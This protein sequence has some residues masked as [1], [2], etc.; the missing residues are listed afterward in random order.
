MVYLRFGGMG[1]ILRR[2]T[3][4]SYAVPA[5]RSRQDLVLAE[6]TNQM[7]HTFSYTMARLT[8]GARAREQI[9]LWVFGTTCL[10]TFTRWC[11]HS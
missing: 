4:V 10:H 2:Q 8:C 7:T 3:T 1:L 11:F 5:P 6:G 9:G